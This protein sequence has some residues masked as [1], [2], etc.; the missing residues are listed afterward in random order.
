MRIAHITPSFLPHRGGV[1]THVA[2][3]SDLQ[4]K[5]GHKVTILTKPAP[6]TKI[7][8]GQF[9]FSK[10]PILLQADSIHVHDVFWWLLPIFPI[11][12]FHRKKIITTFHGWE[13]QFPIRWQA[14]AQRWLYNQLS[15]KAVHVG[16]W[17]QEFYWDK[18][19]LIVYGGV[20]TTSLPSDDFVSRITP[21]HTPLRLVFL[22][23]LESENDCELYFDF[24]DQLTK[25]HIQYTMTWIGDG[26]Y[27][28]KAQTYGEVTGMVDEINS[29]VQRADIVLASSYLSILESQAAGKM[30]VAL[31]S[32]FL[33]QR[34]LETY[35]GF[36]AMI[37]SDNPAAAVVRIKKILSSS[38][39]HQTLQSRI[40]PLIQPLTWEK[41]TTDYQMLYTA[42]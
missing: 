9:I 4:K 31:Y 7:K 16:A 19:D 8:T 30:V 6:H 33:K 26:K 25:N 13:G 22:G 36:S 34:Y 35:P 1:E 14:K 18:P 29:Y 20:N 21:F 23:R 27:R 39:N 37:A 17:I 42:S 24:L 5:A 3:I 2:A 38:K 12:A 41:I 28:A 15:F 10:L 11:L 32:T 40:Y